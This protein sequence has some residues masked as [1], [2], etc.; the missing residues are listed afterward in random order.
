MK[1]TAVWRLFF[2]EEMKF[3]LCLLFRAGAK[4]FCRLLEKRQKSGIFSLEKWQN[5]CVFVLEKRQTEYLR[6]KIGQRL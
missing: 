3:F 4:F 6:Y 1:C 5:Q 2:C